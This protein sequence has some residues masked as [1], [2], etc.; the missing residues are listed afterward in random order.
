MWPVLLVTVLLD[1]RGSGN[2]FMKFR[3][4]F[5]TCGIDHCD[6]VLRWIVSFIRSSFISVGAL[7]AQLMDVVG[8]EASGIQLSRS[9]NLPCKLL[10]HAT[11]GRCRACSA[12]SLKMS[13]GDLDRSRVVFLLADVKVDTRTSGQS[14]AQL[15]EC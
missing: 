13:R 5:M 8:E 14:S 15:L 2:N 10:A 3:S 6:V 11:V 9:I 12:S 7:A 1:L 4:Q